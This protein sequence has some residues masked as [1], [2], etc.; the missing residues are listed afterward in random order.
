MPKK[1]SLDEQVKRIQLIL[2]N[3]LMVKCDNCHFK[4]LPMDKESEQICPNCRIELKE[5]WENNF[6]D[7]EIENDYFTPNNNQFRVN[8]Y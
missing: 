5:Y 2:N 6:D 1:L 8:K 3:P 4:Y 7:Y